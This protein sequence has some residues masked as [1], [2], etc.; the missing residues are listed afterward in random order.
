[1]S[2]LVLLT[3]SLFSGSV[4]DAG[5]AALGH[6]APLPPAMTL[7]ASPQSAIDRQG[8][9]SI[10]GSWF[11]TF[12][13]HQI[14][15]KQTAGSFVA[16]H[17][18]RTDYG[19][20]FSWRME[21]RINRDGVLT[22]LLRYTE[23]LKPSH[24]GYTQSY[25]MRLSAD[26]VE[27]DGRTELPSGG[28]GGRVVWKRLSPPP[29]ATPTPAPATRPPAPAPAKPAAVR[30]DIAGAWT[31]VSNVT[32]PLVFS[33]AGAGWTGYIQFGVNRHPVDR[34]SFNPA[35]GEITFRWVSSAHTYVGKVTGDEMS[36][37]YN[38]GRLKW[39]ARRGATAPAPASAP[40][41]TTTTRTAPRPPATQ[42]AA[43]AAPK[44]DIA[45]TWTLVSNVTVPLVF[46]RAGAG[47]TGYIQ[48]GVNR[49]PVD[50]ISFNP[51]TGEITFRW[52][53]SAHTYVGEV[54][55]DEMS[56]TYNNGRL[57]WRARRGATAPAP[58]SAPPSTTTTRTAP[59][60]P[61]TQPAAPA[62]PKADIAGTWTL[63]SNVTVPL[64][65]SRA[66]A[67]W[68]G[69]I[70]FGVNRH[71]VDRIS[72]NPATGE[73]TF[74]WV[75]SAHTYVGEVTG[76]EMSGTYNNGRLKWSATRKAD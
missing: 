36:G 31:L 37:T 59:R 12:S 66:G 16:T 28:G 10:E 14:E 64:V 74:R 56:G 49:H 4:C 6:P 46:S 71:P 60:P 15:I 62:A 2:Y 7:A 50:R 55:G 24:S 58:A 38:N 25:S 68:T 18:H 76:D 34:I 22:G 39:R 57:K 44:A 54:T 53:S 45:G 41:S 1:M 32:V 9:P 8:F 65:F 70:Q 40:P 3:A 75:S 11:D 63:V 33:R 52:V 27:L 17:T 61:A 19:T 21:G 29:A 23:G 20:V 73:I 30:A 67:G 35:T 43:P 5:Q 69:Y 72:F 48:F 26:G 13:H 47:W 51:A 42:P